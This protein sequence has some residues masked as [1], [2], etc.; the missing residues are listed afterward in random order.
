MKKDL[1]IEGAG[2]VLT[3]LRGTYTLEEFADRLGWDR[4]RLWKYENNKLGLSID[5]LEHVARVTGQRAE[6][7]AFRCLQQRYPNLRS[8]RSEVG[9]LLNRA[10]ELLVQPKD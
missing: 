9:R 3:E 1:K 5:V 8:S 2:S 4:S 7:L 6:L 10:V